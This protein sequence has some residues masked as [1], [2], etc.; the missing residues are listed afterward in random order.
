[1]EDLHYFPNR[2]RRN[3][4]KKKT[5]ASVYIR[6]HWKEDWFFGYQFL[7]GCNPVMIRKCSK[8]PDNFPVTDA[9]VQNSLGSST[10]QQEVKDGKI[11]IVDFKMLDGLDANI[12]NGEQQCL[13]A[14]ICLLHLDQGNRMMPLCLQLQQ[15]PGVH[16]PI[17]LPLDAELDWLLAKMWVKSADFQCHSLISHLPNTHL[18]AETFCVATIRQLPSV[19][20]IYKLLLPHAKYTMQ[21]NTQARQ[22]LIGEGGVISKLLAVG[23]KGR[24]LLSQQEF[25][26]ITYQL[27]CLPDALEL[28]GVA[29]LRVTTT[30]MMD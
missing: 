23:T 30:R 6:D 1:M 10:L 26:A 24:L 29:D 20:P 25:L 28:R 4:Q 7:N 19:H 3:G 11:F 9:M 27:L 18:V 5:T 22:D 21:I 15:T 17:F 2:Q 14:P 16:N 12:I 13:V 8:I